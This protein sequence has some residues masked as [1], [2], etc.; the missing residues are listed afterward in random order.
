MKRAFQVV[1]LLTVGFGLSGCHGPDLNALRTRAAYD[2]RCPAADLKLTELS[3][4]QPTNGA[5][6]LYGVDGCGKRGAYV[7]EGGGLWLLDSGEKSD[8]K[9]E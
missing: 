8:K 6:A 9:S 2:M 7:Q 3:A 4:G 5:G 1:G